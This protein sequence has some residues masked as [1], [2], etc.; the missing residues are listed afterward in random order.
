MTDMQRLLTELDELRE[1]NRRL[2]NEKGDVEEQLNAVLKENK[3]L[4]AERDAELKRYEEQ[5]T[6]WPGR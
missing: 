5:E 4:K 1:E 6:L 2:R 3:K